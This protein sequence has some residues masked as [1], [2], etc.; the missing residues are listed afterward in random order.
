MAKITLVFDGGSR[1][2]SGAGFGSYAFV[3]DN[4]HTVTRLEF[5]DGMSSVEA[6][7]DT[8]I[9]A[10]QTLIR[11]EKSPAD[12]LLEIHTANHLII[13]QVKGSWE[14][15]EAPMK[16]RRNQVADLLRQ[17]GAAKLVRVTRDQVSRMLMR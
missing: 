3:R 9:N 4:Q 6:G 13:N 1:G 2:E 15:R 7:Y 17:F 8:L 10:L 12:V 14:A 5:G 11:Q 16:A